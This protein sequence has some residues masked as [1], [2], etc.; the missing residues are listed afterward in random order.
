MTQMKRSV[1]QK[2]AHRHREQARGCRR[3]G[4]VQEGRVGS[5]GLAD[6]N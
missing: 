5:S 6:T 3:G 4:G 2:Q 1:K